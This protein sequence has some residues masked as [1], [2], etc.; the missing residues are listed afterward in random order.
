MSARSPAETSST[1]RSRPMVWKQEYS[2]P[3]YQASYR[4]GLVPVCHWY[5]IPEKNVLKAIR[6]SVEILVGQ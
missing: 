3:A 6:E 5:G 4:A 1:R 2:I